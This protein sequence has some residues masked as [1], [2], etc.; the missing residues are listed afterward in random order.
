MD[1]GKTIIERAHGKGMLACVM[2]VDEG[3]LAASR[4]NVIF[5]T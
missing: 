2:A 1:P 5:I 4:F 3:M